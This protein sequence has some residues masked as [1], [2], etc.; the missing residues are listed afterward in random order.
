M[1]AAANDKRISSVSDGVHNLGV[2][3]DRR[4]ASLESR[5]APAGDGRDAEIERLKKEALCDD[6]TI[7]YLRA[8]LAAS[9]ARYATTSS[10]AIGAG[11]NTTGELRANR[12]QLAA[13][14]A[15]VTA[16]RDRLAAQVRTLEARPVLDAERL[17]GALEF[18][19][20]QHQPKML[21]ERILDAL[22]AVTLPAGAVG[23]EALLAAYTASYD[24]ALATDYRDDMGS[25]RNIRACRSAGIR[26]VR[27]LLTQPAPV[28]TSTDEC[29]DCG[30]DFSNPQSVCQ[31][32]ESPAP[33][34]AP[35]VPPVVAGAVEG[36]AGTEWREVEPGPRSMASGVHT[37]TVGCFVMAV[38][39]FAADGY[40]NWR[41]EIG[42]LAAGA[43]RRADVAAAKAAA[44]AWATEQHA[45][46]ARNL[47]LPR[48]A[49]AVSAAGTVGR[50]TWRRLRRGDRFSFDTSPD[51]IFTVE[52]EPTERPDGTLAL[53]ARAD[54]PLGALAR[55]IKSNEH[56]E[57]PSAAVTLRGPVVP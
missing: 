27:A 26:A 6:E 49:P 13:A 21:A 17:A 4:L 48:P 42:P 56:Y 12:E 35:P 39:D 9:E 2:D 29:P 16:D 8:D 25:A 57:R 11:F 15:E 38:A 18:L 47:G 50:S 1:N 10:S 19:R 20:H 28:A 52:S 5:T 7:R 46:M 23:D 43:G 31:C 36:G 45:A 37:R 3:T 32:P 51:E 24:G 54:D 30:A 40:A 53:L 22:G 34:S 14:L 44:D 33:S 55:T 41:V